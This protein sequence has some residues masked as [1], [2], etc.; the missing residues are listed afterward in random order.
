MCGDKGI[1]Y[2]PL[3]LHTWCAERFASRF[4]LLMQCDDC[5]CVQDAGPLSPEDGSGEGKR[6]GHF[7]LQAGMQSRENH[8]PS[9]VIR[10]VVSDILEQH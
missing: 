3:Q 1:E 10:G 6:N 4:S 9:S 8:H 5:S 2:K 7:L